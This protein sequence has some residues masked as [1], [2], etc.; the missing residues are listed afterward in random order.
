MSKFFKRVG[1]L[2]QKFTF[3]IH[4]HSITMTLSIPVRVNVIW[5]MRNKRIETS[6]KPALSPS[7]GEAI[8]D[9]GLSMINTLYTKKKTDKVLDK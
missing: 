2:A 9:E 5:K 6:G 3:D 4:I 8:L 7:T 1:T